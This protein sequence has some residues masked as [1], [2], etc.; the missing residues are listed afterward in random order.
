MN[1][2]KTFLCSIL[3][4]LLIPTVIVSSLLAFVLIYDPL[5]IFPKGYFIEEQFVPSMRE[6]GKGIIDNVDFDSVIIG[7]SMLQNS[8]AVELT[9]LRNDNSL[10]VN[11]SMTAFRFYER[12]FILDYLFKNKKINN[13]VYS[14][15]ATYDEV[16]RY[17]IQGYNWTELYDEIQYNDINIYYDV[18]IIIKTIMSFS[19]TQTHAHSIFFDRATSWYQ[20][21]RHQVL[22]GGI[23]NWVK[24]SSKETLFGYIEGIHQC[25]NN[26]SRNNDITLSVEDYKSSIEY[27]EQ[28]LIRFV[29]DNPQ[30][31]F[32]IL[33][34]PYFR[35]EY[36]K[37]KQSKGAKF[38]LHQA[39]TRYLVDMGIK[40]PNLKIYG[41]EDM[42]FLDDFANYRDFIHYHYSF[43]SMMNH[44]IANGEHLLTVDNIDEYLEKCDNLA[45]N[46]DI[47]KLYNDAC[48]IMREQGINPKTGDKF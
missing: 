10:F 16:K 24:N 37:W 20:N 22:Y 30:T 17:D 28:N 7:T 9:S 2:K 1:Y 39:M 27:V 19:L 33:I 44:A 34:P 29:R 31:M 12:S 14:F 4:A 18:R 6:Q 40:Y 48:T 11:L 13:I 26:I 46:F 15:D 43:N 36:A 47:K 25:V 8:S 42:P 21:P 23:E 41:F 45:Q 38:I 32:H 35:Y 5:Q 3:G